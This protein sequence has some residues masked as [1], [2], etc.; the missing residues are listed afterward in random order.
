MSSI[1]INNGL[2]CLFADVIFKRT[3]QR[4]EDIIDIKYQMNPHFLIVQ[5]RFL[6]VLNRDNCYI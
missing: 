5:K 6:F 1:E 3:R 2:L 4:K